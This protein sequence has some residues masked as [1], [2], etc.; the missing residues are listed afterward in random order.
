MPP[1]QCN[2]ENLFFAQRPGQVLQPFPIPSAF[3]HLDKRD[4]QPARL[5]NI[6]S[7]EKRSQVAVAKTAT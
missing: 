7:T 2:Q 1:G 5:R 4:R 3:I 6:P